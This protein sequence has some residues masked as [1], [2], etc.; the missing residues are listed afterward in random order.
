MNPQL[1]VV[2]GLNVYQLQMGHRVGLLQAQAALQLIG[3]FKHSPMAGLVDLRRIDVSS[4][5]VVIATTGQG[6][7]ITFA[8][9]NLDQ[10]LRRWREIYDLGMSRNK[11]IASLDL[12]VENN[13]PVRWAEII[14]AAVTLKKS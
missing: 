11:M 5:G 13:V 7:E 6:G 1:P 4:P 10:Q 8:L 12:A 3:A 9:D 2:T 14:S